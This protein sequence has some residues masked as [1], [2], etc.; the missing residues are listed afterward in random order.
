ML[1]N[2]DL[3]VAPPKPGAAPDVCRHALGRSMWVSYS[4]LTGN[5]QCADDGSPAAGRWTRQS[6]LD[7]RPAADQWVAGTA[8]ISASA[9]SGSRPTARSPRDDNLAAFADR[10]PPKCAFTRHRVGDRSVGLAQTGPHH[11]RN[12]LAAAAK[13][14]DSS[15]IMIAAATVAVHLASLDLVAFTRKPS[16]LLTEKSS[17]APLSG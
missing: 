10:Q 12:Q 15:D 1:G 16:C 8:E 17:R 7:N 5:S 11:E 13:G 6:V 2:L 3:S 9:E 14:G 4:C